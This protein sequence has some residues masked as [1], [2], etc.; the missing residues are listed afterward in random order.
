MQLFLL[1]YI[2]IS[3]CEIFSVGGIPLNWKVRVVSSDQ[4]TGTYSYSLG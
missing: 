3:I 4:G 1:G 2:V